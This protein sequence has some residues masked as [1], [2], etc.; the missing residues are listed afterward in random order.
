MARPQARLADGSGKKSGT[1]RSKVGF[2]FVKLSHTGPRIPACRDKQSCPH[3]RM[4]IDEGRTTN[5]EKIR[6]E[7]SVN[8][9][10]FFV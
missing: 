10:F 6:F 5:K 3:W 7:R 8:R 9:A 1:L 2:F 4:M